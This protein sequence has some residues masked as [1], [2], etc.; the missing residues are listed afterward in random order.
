MKLHRVK[1]GRL[2]NQHKHSRWSFM[3]HE[4]AGQTLEA[5]ALVHEA[6]LRVVGDDPKK[7]GRGHGLERREA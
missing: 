3:A 5:T 6:Y 4:Q 1:A 2:N 7:P